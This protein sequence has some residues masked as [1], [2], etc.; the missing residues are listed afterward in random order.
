MD[1][2]Q[3]LCAT[4]DLTPDI[5]EFLLRPDNFA[6][7]PYPA[8]SHINVG[9]TIGGLP[10]TRSYSLV[11]E[12]GPDGYRIAVRR[13]PDPRRLAIYVVARAGARL[14]H[15]VADLAVFHRLEPATLLPDRRRHRHHAA[16]GR[17]ADAGAPQRGL[18]RCITPCAPAAMRL[19]GSA[20]RLLGGRLVVHAGDE[21]RRLD[22]GAAFAALPA[23]P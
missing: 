18:L 4:R 21:N 22:L 6:G 23:M 1:H 2:R 3:P 14:E 12:A 19:S 11:G 9:V 15:H 10:A 8:G 20:H 16:R 13:A 5:R 7:A 17:R